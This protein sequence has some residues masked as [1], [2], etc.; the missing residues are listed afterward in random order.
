M[1]QLLKP[2]HLEP[3][4]HTKISHRNEKPMNGNEA[5]PPLA[6]TRESPL[7]MIKAQYNQKIKNKYIN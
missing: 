1:L 3:V 2:M 5:K 7:A 6:A 4:L